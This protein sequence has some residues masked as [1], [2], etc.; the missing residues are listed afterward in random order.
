MKK[1]L[2]D[3][4]L[5]AMTFGMVSVS[6]AATD[7][8]KYVKKDSL[9]NDL[10]VRD[11]TQVSQI[12]RLEKPSG[13]MI[14]VQPSFAA[15]DYENSAAFTDKI[16]S[17]LATALNTKFNGGLGWC[18]P[19]P[20]KVQVCDPLS[21][22]VVVNP[23]FLGFYLIWADEIAPVYEAKDLTHAT[24]ISLVNLKED[25]ERL[26]SL[27]LKIEELDFK[28]LGSLGEKLK[29]MPLRLQNAKP[30]NVTRC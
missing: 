15:T 14:G 27:R 26:E 20:K 13:N 29:F 21:N 1:T 19:D 2:F 11:L 30:G 4:T 16:E 9:G 12:S 5:M 24:L 17:Y 3:G 6:D 7:V 25:R 22:T 10:Y 8:L 23:E 28:N 18:K